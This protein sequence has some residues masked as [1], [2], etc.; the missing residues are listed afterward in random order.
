MTA[1]VRRQVSTSGGRTWPFYRPVPTLM[2]VVL[3]LPLPAPHRVGLGQLPC[4]AAVCLISSHPAQSAP[5]WSLPVPDRVQP[6]T[7]AC[8]SCTQACTMWHSCPEN[9]SF[10]AFSDHARCPRVQVVQQRTVLSP[11]GL[12]A[13][14]QST[15]SSLCPHALQAS[16]SC[17][18]AGPATTC[19]S[20]APA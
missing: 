4:W 8:Q 1:G 11:P 19:T 20:S 3:E 5:Q 16:R 17:S 2:L 10:Y 15:P 18:R 13:V 9:D 6:L 12:Q 7:T 14:Q